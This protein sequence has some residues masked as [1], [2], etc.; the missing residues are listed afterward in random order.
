MKIVFLETNS[1]GDDMDLSL[2]GKFGELERYPSSTEEEAR[3]RTRDADIVFSNKI[4]MNEHTLGEADHLS[5]IGVTATGTNN[6]DMDYMK[7]HGITVTNVAG[8]STDSVA[9][10]TFAMLFYLLEKLRYFDEFVQSGA[11]SRS[12]LFCHYGEKFWELA[13]KTWGIIGLGAIGRRVARIAES[14][15]CRVIYYS[16]SGKNSNAEYERVDFDTLLKSSDI[17]SVHAPL[18]AATE[19]IMDY[20]AF[21]KMKETSY[22]INVGRGPIVNEA[23]LVRALEE[24]QIAGAGLD[25]MSVEPLPADNPLLRIQDSRR[26]LLTPHI[27]WASREARLRLIGE[28]EKNLEAYLRGENR[29]RVV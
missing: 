2:F 28:L 10:H 19:G 23:D 29:N 22:F 8:Y 6:I 5:Y 12:D 18:N 20:A 4:M 16:T 15:G 14:F 25:V 1:L 21:S 17:V 13:G 11:Y 7:R 3:E 24:G 27:A 9:Q 26:L